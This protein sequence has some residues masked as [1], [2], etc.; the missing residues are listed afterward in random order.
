MYLRQRTEFFQSLLYFLKVLFQYKNHLERVDLM[1]QLP[2]WMPIA[3]VF[4]SG[5]VLFEGVL[6]L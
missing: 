3:I 4:A 6:F 5:G 2:R 1:Y